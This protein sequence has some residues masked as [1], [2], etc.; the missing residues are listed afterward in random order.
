MSTC[1]LMTV[2][3]QKYEYLVFKL[4]ASAP[5]AFISSARSYSQ[6]VF[7]QLRTCVSPCTH[8]RAL[9][10]T[11]F[12]YK[13]RAAF[14]SNYRKHVPQYTLYAM[15]HFSNKCFTDMLQAGKNFLTDSTKILFSINLFTFYLSLFQWKCC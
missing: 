11:S 12:A 3:V 9:D 5:A 7:L 4:S 2:T 6:K 10:D 15:Y 1:L 8:E 14:A 13:K